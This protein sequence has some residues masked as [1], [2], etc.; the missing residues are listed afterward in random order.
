MQRIIYH[1]A[2]K[3]KWIKPEHLEG[4]RTLVLGSFN[5]YNPNGAHIDYYYGRQTNHFWKAIALIIGESENYFF[6]KKSGF[7][8]KLSIM[9]GRFACLDFIESIELDSENLIDLDCYIREKIFS[10]YLDQ[11]IWVTNTKLKGS[12]INVS[13]NYNEQIIKT[14]NDGNQFRKVIHT[15][16]ETRIFPTGTKP[17]EHKLGSNGL[18]GF[19]NRVSKICREKGIEF[20]LKSISPSDYAVKNGSTNLF[21]LSN[22]LKQNLW[23]Q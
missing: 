13:R 1:Q 19:V 4:P 21:E 16:G 7:E 11:N 2:S 6:D 22:W 20:V 9:K 14:L 10:N 3:L 12:L 5:P 8:R 18:N 23:L 17:K 15:M